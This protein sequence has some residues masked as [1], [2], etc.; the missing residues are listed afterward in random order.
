MGWG[1]NDKQAAEQAMTW[2]VRCSN[3][4]SALPIDGSSPPKNRCAKKSGEFYTREERFCNEHPTTRMRK[5]LIE[6]LNKK[7]S[8]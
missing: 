8:E 5:K 1:L 6:K 4:D 7:R 2:L 3:C